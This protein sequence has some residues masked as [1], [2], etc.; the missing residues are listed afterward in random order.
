[1]LYRLTNKSIKT[2]TSRDALKN[3]FCD[4]CQK[5][6]ARSNELDSHYSSYEHNHRQRL[7]DMKQM[8]KDP[9]AAEKARK[10]EKKADK[11]AGLLSV[12]L[13]AGKKGGEVKKKGG[14]KTVFKA[15]GSKE[16]EKKEDVVEREAEVKTEAD[17]KKEEIKIPG[18]GSYQP[19]LEEVD[20]NEEEYEPEISDSV[21]SWKVE[22][23]FSD[24][25]G[26][27]AYDPF[28]PSGCGQGCDCHLLRA[29]RI[30]SAAGDEKNVWKYF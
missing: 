17:V 6:Y 16:E 12:K 3:F 26:D 24:E 13:D 9:H 28:H 7:K 23:L 4:L 21:V 8:Q 10:A 22:G 5:G 1:M 27:D 29:R 30:A 19:N 15:S 25:N 11:A 20:E 14:F 18:L 2:E